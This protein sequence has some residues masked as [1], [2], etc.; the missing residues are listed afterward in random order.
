MRPVS[1]H[2]IDI[3]TAL[4]ALTAL[5][6]LSCSSGSST[7]PD[8]TARDAAA[9]DAEPGDAALPF[10]AGA[11]DATAADASTALDAA[12]TLDAAT[13]DAGFSCAV[14]NG[15]C[16]VHATCTSSAGAVLCRCAPGFTGDGATCVD[17]AASLSGLRWSL[18]CDGN[19]S[20]AVCAAAP[21][22]VTSTTLRGAPGSRYDVTLRFRGVVEQK[23]YSGGDSDGAYFQIGGSDNGDTYNVYSLSISSST[24]TYF[25]N[26][27]QSGMSRC[28]P[29]DYTKTIRMTA[30]STVT[31]TAQSK[32]NQEIR[33]IDGSG[34]PIVVP[35]IA[36][37]PAAFDG[38]F[39]QMDVQNVTLAH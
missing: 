30:G 35:G 32:D 10:D 12:T 27:G 33:N 4:L 18:P 1:C 15:G 5:T 26:R 20:S 36:P 9:P 29:L 11:A 6:A 2:P 22:T 17:V 16:S 28:W 39:I 24:T 25:L 31:L 38:Q 19:I 34:T 8:A 14:N 37:A 21:Q 13:P 7:A 23:T 3:A